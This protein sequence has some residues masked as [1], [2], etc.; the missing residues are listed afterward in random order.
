MS[1][2]LINAKYDQ[3]QIVYLKTDEC[4]KERI[5]SGWIIRGETILYELCCSDNPTYIAYEY[6]ISDE[7]DWI[8][9]TS[10]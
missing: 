9:S 8:L 3:K 10:N 4:Q 7:K 5:V 1:N 6:E 2:Y